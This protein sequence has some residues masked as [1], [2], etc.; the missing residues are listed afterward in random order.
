MTDYEIILSILN[1]SN[2]M[3]DHFYHREVEVCNPDGT[4]EKRTVISL[5]ERTDQVDL[6]FDENGN[7]L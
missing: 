2:Y 1:K 7:I 6:D 5:I 4:I 3:R